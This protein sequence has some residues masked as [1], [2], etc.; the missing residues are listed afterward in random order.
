[1]RQTELTS[2]EDQHE[3]RNFYQI[4]YPEAYIFVH[5]R[6]T[7]IDIDQ[8][9]DQDGVPQSRAEVLMQV[10]DNTTPQSYSEKRRLDRD[11]K[12][13]FDIGRFLQ[14]FM[15]GTLKDDSTFDYDDDSKM[16]S[17]H[18]VT[19]KLKYNGVF[20]WQET[21]EIINGAYEPLDDWWSGQRR[22]RWWYNFPFT[23]DFRNLYE[24]SITINSGTT[25]MA[26]IAQILPDTMS[27]S[28]IRLNPKSITLW[29][30]RM[31][32]TTGAGMGFLHGT[33]S[34][35][36]SNSVLLIGHQCLPSEKTVYLRWLNRH[37]EMNYWLFYQQARQRKTTAI[38][39]KRAYVKDERF[40]AGIIDNALLRTLSIEGELTCFTDA[41][42][43]IDYD[44]VRQIITAPFV[45]LYLPDVS[46]SLNEETWQRVHVKAGTYTELL[47]HADKYTYN[48]QVTLT[49]T[50]PEEGQIFV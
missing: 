1:M 9:L 27:Y 19:V 3:D 2:F 31:L 25:Q 4:T 48:R 28:R 16:V 14:I 8:L 13:T 23:F 45:D 20:F 11:S 29:A 30:N 21:F 40:A 5:S 7:Y 38:D 24:A 42:D 49:L 6:H 37:G 35:A 47:R 46:D 32:V 33:F 12:A 22:L 36:R 15:E 50:L 41:L 17:S 44:I 39:S 26:Q 43:G 10:I 18:G 34:A